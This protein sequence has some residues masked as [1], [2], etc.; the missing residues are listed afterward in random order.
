MIAWALGISEGT[1]RTVMANQHFGKLGDLWKHLPL[2][3]VLRLAP[4]AH[5]WETHAGSAAYVLTESP[6]RLHGAIRFLSVA[7]SDR[8]LAGSSY[9]EA[10]LANPGI[11]FKRTCNKTLA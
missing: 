1:P 5:Y 8:E 3:E 10:L 7:R 6:A 2:P 9:L 11:Y 4:P